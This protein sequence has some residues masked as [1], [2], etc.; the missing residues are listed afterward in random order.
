MRF[1]LELFISDENL[2]SFNK[3]DIK[4]LCGFFFKYMIKSEWYY[5]NVE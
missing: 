3:I 1:G 5:F 2:F 4:R